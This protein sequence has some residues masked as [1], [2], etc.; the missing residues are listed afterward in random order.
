[1]AMFANWGT[2]TFLL[3]VVPLSK[4]IE[5]KLNAI[6]HQCSSFCAE[7]GLKRCT[8]FVGDSFAVADILAPTPK[9]TSK[10]YHKGINTIMV[11]CR[12]T[13]VR[14]FFSS[15]VLWPQEHF[16]VV[17]EP[18]TTIRPC[19]SSGKRRSFICTYVLYTLHTA[20]M[21]GLSSTV[22]AG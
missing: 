4:M 21:P 8:H 7:G 20:L 12:W 16:C 3:A 19:F 6:P 14:P 11:A 5:V 1:M 2:I 10:S 18:F 17:A 13:C 9:K 22:S 15:L